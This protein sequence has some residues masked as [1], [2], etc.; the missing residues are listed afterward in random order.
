MA[1]TSENSSSTVACSSFADR[2]CWLDATLGLLGASS[3]SLPRELLVEL[4][5]SA[6]LYQPPDDMEPGGLGFVHGAHVHGGRSRVPT[7]LDHFQGVDSRALYLGRLLTRD[8]ACLI[9]LASQGGPEVG[10]GLLEASRSYG[11]VV[12]LNGG[13]YCRL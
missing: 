7:H 8:P 2:S 1:Q 13:C 12:A 5:L 9:L 6:L 10:V 11:F 3:N 4:P